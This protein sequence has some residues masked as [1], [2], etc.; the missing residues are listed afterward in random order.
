MV[1]ASS[2]LRRVIATVQGGLD[3]WVEVVKAIYESGI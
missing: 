2:E 3:T 1:D